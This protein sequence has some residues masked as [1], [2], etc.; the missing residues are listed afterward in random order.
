M[1]RGTFSRQGSAATFAMP[2][3]LT[4]IPLDP[5]CMPSLHPFHPPPADAQAVSEPKPSTAD[6]PT[7][8]M[9]TSA[10]LHTAPATTNT[11]HPSTA[12]TQPQNAAQTNDDAPYNISTQHGSGLQSANSFEQAQRPSNTSKQPHLQASYLSQQKTP[13]Q[14]DPIVQNSH[15]CQEADLIL[16]E[17]AYECLTATGMTPSYR[18][19]WEM[20]FTVQRKLRQVSADP[21]APSDFERHQQQVLLDMPLPKRLLTLREKHEMLY[22]HA[23][24]QM[25]CSLFTHRQQEAGEAGVEAGVEAGTVA[26]TVAGHGEVE[27]KEGWEQELTDDDHVRPRSPSLVWAG[28]PFGSPSRDLSYSPSHDMPYSPSND[29]PYSSSND[30]DNLVHSMTG[31]TDN[32]NLMPAQ[33]PPPTANNNPSEPEPTPSDPQLGASTSDA[34]LPGALFFAQ[35]SAPQ[36]GSMALGES[37]SPRAQLASQIGGIAQEGDQLPTET[38]WAASA[39]LLPAALPAVVSD[40]PWSAM[41]IDATGALPDCAA[42]DAQG[43][44]PQYTEGGSAVSGDA[45]DASKPSGGHAVYPQTSYLPGSSAQHGAAGKA[46]IATH[47]TAGTADSAQRGEAGTADNAQ[48]GQAGTADS[49]QLR[50]AGLSYRSYRLGGYSMVARAATPLTVPPRPHSK[51]TLWLL[52]GGKMFMHCCNCSSNVHCTSAPVTTSR[53]CDVHHEPYSRS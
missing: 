32:S 47:G 31:L 16:T 11:H 9:S 27:Q 34:P 24:C 23:I 12:A 39:E 25:G 18:G 15:A 19:S 40:G 44:G 43:A 48:H 37:Q 26:G 2:E 17:G 38:N 33:S 41:D 52:V 53:A 45:A 10:S 21:R 28:T 8:H 36:G 35:A 42:E 22:Q 20:P 13:L 4:P 1:Y 29:A 14:H 30:A 6:H 5:P 49:V 46:D 7:A 3:P 51:V 50:E